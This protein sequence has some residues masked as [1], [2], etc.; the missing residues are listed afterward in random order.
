MFREEGA[1]E[2]SGYQK[3]QYHVARTDA[4]QGDGADVSNSSQDYTRSQRAPASRH[5]R[6]MTELHDLKSFQKQSHEYGTAHAAYSSRKRD[7]TGASRS[8]APKSGKKAQL[9]IFQEDQGFLPGEAESVQLTKTTAEEAAAEAEGNVARASLKKQSARYEADAMA[10]ESKEQSRSHQAEVNAA[11]ADAVRKA[12]T[13]IVIDDPR[14]AS[15]VKI[16]KERLETTVVLLQQKLNDRED[17]DTLSA[18]LLEGK[19]GAERERDELKSENFTLKG[20]VEE[21][22]SHKQQLQKEL[23]AQI[24][25]LRE[26]NQQNQVVTNDMNEVSKENINLQSEN[27]ELKHLKQ[28][29]KEEIDSLRQKMDQINRQNNNLISENIDL[30]GRI[31]ELEKQLKLTLEENVQFKDLI[32]KL[33]TE[34]NS[35]RESSTIEISELK[36]ERTSLQKSVQTK[37]VTIE[38]L[39][40]IIKTKNEEIDLLLQQK[41]NVKKDNDSLNKKFIS[42]EEENYGFKKTQLDILVQLK[43]LQV[44]LKKEQE[45]SNGLTSQLQ[46]TRNNLTDANQSIKFAQSKIAMLQSKCE[47]LAAN[48]AIYI[49][50]AGDPIDMAMA[51]F[52]NRY[53]ERQRMKILF[54]RES[55]GVY[56]F[57]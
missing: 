51:K 46:E 14:A 44:A 22:T 6:K 27:A 4:R 7:Q 23:S 20:K 40:A 2:Q 34:L 37:I 57:G 54:L 36:I 55:E 21:L 10:E 35:Y 1:F 50:K 38:E 52:I 17:S 56:K 41:E 29:N 42:Y 49:G 43:Y 12:E 39:N 19:R 28:L 26:A 15:E 11:A 48:Q 45:K 24:G 53:P 5:Q 31:T 9:T 47:E 16:E 32:S 18:K 13:D 25:L 3:Q 33:K 8:P 30:K